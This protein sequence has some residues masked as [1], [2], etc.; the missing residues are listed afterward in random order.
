MFL[1][2][3]HCLIV[4]IFPLQE[5]EKDKDVDELEEIYNKSGLELERKRCKVV[6]TW[7]YEF[8]EV[9]LMLFCFFTLNCQH[10]NFYYFLP[11]RESMKWIILSNNLDKIQRW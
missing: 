4:L 5:E 2:F 3:S 10:Y 1:W 11:K 6:S 9:T 8:L 7:H